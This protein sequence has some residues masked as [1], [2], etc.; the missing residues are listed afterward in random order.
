MIYQKNITAVY[1]SL[2]LTGTYVISLVGVTLLVIGFY[3]VW[4]GDTEG[5]ILIMPG[6]VSL[7]IG[8]LFTKFLKKWV[9]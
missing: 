1:D 6:V 5:I 4:I 2:A 8:T 9:D 3:N 7:V